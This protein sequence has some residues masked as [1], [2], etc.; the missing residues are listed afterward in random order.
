VLI[1]ELRAEGRR[2]WLVGPMRLLLWFRTRRQRQE[3]EAAARFI[4]SIMTDFLAALEQIGTG[5]LPCP[6]PESRPLETPAAP[7]RPA[8]ARHRAREVGMDE[9]TAP[10]PATANPARHRRPAVEPGR[11]RYG[12]PPARE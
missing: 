2:G 3:A 6:Q 9:G 1:G 5:K 11:V 10:A 4:Q 12:F 8:R 7:A